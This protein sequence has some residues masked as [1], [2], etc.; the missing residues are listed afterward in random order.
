MANQTDPS[1]VPAADAV[2]HGPEFT[3]L[4]APAGAAEHPERPGVALRPTQ[5]PTG[6]TT[7]WLPL[8]SADAAATPD[9]AV[10]PL[11]DGRAG[12]WGGL[13]A[14]ASSAAG[15]AD[16]TRID[17]LSVARTLGAAE[18]FDGDKSPGDDTQSLTMATTPTVWRATQLV[19]VGLGGNQDD[20]VVA[21]LVNGDFVIAWTNPEVDGPTG[22]DVMAARYDPLGNMIGNP[23]NISVGNTAR[24]DQDPT[25][26]AHP[27]SPANGGFVH[28]YESVNG[29]SKLMYLDWAGQFLMN[30][31]ARA[32]NP[33]VAVRPDGSVVIVYEYAN[34][35]DLSIR[36]KIYSLA[37]GLGPEFIIRAD[38]DPTTTG[39]DP[40]GVELTVL[41]DGTTIVVY[42]EKDGSDY[43]IE[44]RII[45]PDDSL[46]A[47][48]NVT[49][50][51][52]LDA[53]PQIKT[54]AGGGFAIVWTK[55]GDIKGR[56][57]DA[58]ASAV[59]GIFDVEAG[60]D[61]TNEPALVALKDGG[62]MVVYDDDTDDSLEAR[63]FD[64]AGNQVGSQITLDSGASNIRFPQADLMSDGRV[65]VTWEKNDDIFTRILDPRP[66]IIQLDG[67]EVVATSRPGG[68][69]IIGSALADNI[70]GLDGG[71][72][73]VGS[74]GD[75]TITGGTGKD[76]IFGGAGDDVIRGGIGGDVV[77][78]NGGNDVIT[79][80]GGGPV[81]AGDG[82]DVVEYRSG[83]ISAGAQSVQGGLGEDT[84]WSDGSWR[85]DLV[86]D[87]EAGTRG[88]LGNLSAWEE[89]EHT[90]NTS[91][92]DNSDVLGTSGAN[93]IVT[94]GGTNL[95]DGRAGDDTL[96]GGAGND[97]VL[98]GAGA[99]LMQGGAGSD[100]LGGG[101]GDDTLAGGTG[102]DWLYG[103]AGDD[104]IGGDDGDDRLDG[105]VGSDTLAG[106]LGDDT[107]LGGADDDRAFGGD[108]NDNVNGNDGDDFLRGGADG[109]RVSGGAGFDTVFGDGGNDNVLGFGGND[110][111]RGGDGDDLV[112]GSF[113]NDRLFGDAGDDRIFGGNAND[114]IFGGTGNDLIFGQAGVDRMAG[115]AG[116]DRFIFQEVA[117]STAA[118]LDV[119]VDFQRGLDLI[120]LIALDADATQAGNQAFS[121]IGGAAFTG[122]AGELRFASNSSFLLLSGDVDGD[123]VRDFQ[124]RLDGVAALSVAD[125]LL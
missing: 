17:W 122:T 55:S 103:A 13:S 106:G 56:V 73:I 41:D 43:D 12:D 36:G 25:I 84:I 69:T 31:D 64:A 116:S 119:I 68:A 52:T 66:T 125:I 61:N 57:Y 63:R 100:L 29:S 58:S 72:S 30:F 49:A 53:N 67:T 51:T 33:R 111:L 114:T 1:A 99:D 65:V 113:G 45:N 14:E 19:N 121:F 77:F 78:G 40:V 87:L 18:K 6:E 85:D 123:A 26:A 10:G 83:N 42:R 89:F 75:D 117:D 92:G 80:G 104:D 54:L 105:G 107:L 101:A 86:W 28:V 62:F 27:T 109:D 38:N 71:D 48:I 96:D 50:D 112:G 124:L 97:T 60:S 23:F 118:N 102:K 7:S 46:G 76:T 91:A 5:R 15:T 37:T 11:H 74:D 120:N 95:I 59:T 93:S 70:V 94:G 90:F 8:T 21:V 34:G 3:G 35:T 4:P 16:T 98:G 79:Y 110:L 24:F 32:A 9:V 44:F 22:T 2:V 47:A 81:N 20:P 82:N 115:N 108:G 39:S 88:F